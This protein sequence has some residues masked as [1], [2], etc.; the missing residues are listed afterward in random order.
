MSRRRTKLRVTKN[1]KICH[2]YVASASFQVLNFSFTLQGEFT[3][4]GVFNLFNAYSQK[5]VCFKCTLNCPSV[6]TTPGRTSSTLTMHE[7]R[8][9]W[10]RSFWSLAACILKSGIGNDRGPLYIILQLIAQPPQ[11]HRIPQQ[12]PYGSLTSRPSSLR[13]LTAA[14]TGFRHTEPDRHGFQ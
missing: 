4:R 3:C 7:A 1:S 5:I 8:R 12:W 14:G 6:L 13:P 9:H 11:P 2:E 10:T